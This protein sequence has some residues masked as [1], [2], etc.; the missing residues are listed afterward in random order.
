M[1]SRKRK[2]PVCWMQRRKLTFKDAPLARGVPVVIVPAANVEFIPPPFGCA[3][4]VSS[5]VTCTVT[6]HGGDP[7]PDA[8][9]VTA[10]LIGPTDAATTPESG[11]RSAVPGGDGK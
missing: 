9:Q 4:G 7:A 2:V 3:A 1:M 10:S 8:V 5:V 11:R 6:V